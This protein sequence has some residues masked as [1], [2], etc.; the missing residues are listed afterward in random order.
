MFL[1]TSGAESALHRV[2]LGHMKHRLPCTSVV[3]ALVLPHIF[4]SR[5]PVDNP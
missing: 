3:S 5:E 1:L 4:E 2:M